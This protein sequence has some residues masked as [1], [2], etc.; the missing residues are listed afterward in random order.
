MK[1][2]NEYNITKQ[3]KRKIIEKKNKINWILDLNQSNTNKGKKSSDTIFFYLCLDNL[4]TDSGNLFHTI[5]F[6]KDLSLT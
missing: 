1:K 5:L 6:A 2:P 4:G 3:N